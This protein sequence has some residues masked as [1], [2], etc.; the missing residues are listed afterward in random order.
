MWDAWSLHLRFLRRV[1]E[2]MFP[3]G[4]QALSNRSAVPCQKDGMPQRGSCNPV[5]VRLLMIIGLAPKLLL[6]IVL[7]WCIPEA[8]VRGSVGRP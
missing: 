6:A 2:R 5:W 1:F 8:E 4:W 3:S 7:L